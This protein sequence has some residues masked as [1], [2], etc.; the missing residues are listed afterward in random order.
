M[1]KNIIACVIALGLMG[2]GAHAANSNNTVIFHGAVSATTCDITPFQNGMLLTDSTI[3]L[4]TVAPHAEGQ[5][6]EFV[7]KAKDAND[8]ACAA[9]T[10][11][12]T[13]TVAWTSAFLNANGLIADPSSSVATDAQVL[14]NSVNAKTPGAITASANTA[15]F[16]ADKV[17]GEGLKF[18]A[19]AKGG[20]IPGTFQTAVSFSVAYK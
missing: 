20:T 8:P 19:K 17:I 5:A 4:G 3:Y 13:A 15:D 9:L 10:A 6:K 11:Q 2:G 16:T 7:L 18:N 14:L 12:Q 1:E